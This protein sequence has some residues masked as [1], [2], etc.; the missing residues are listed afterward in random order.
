MQP[1]ETFLAHYG[2]KGMRWGR[3]KDRT[4]QAVEVKASPGRK[5][6]AKGGKFH[7][8]SDDAIIAATRRQQA[9]KSTTDSLS[10]QELQ[11]LV[12]RMNLEQQYKNL[13]SNNVGVGK[14]VARTLLGQV[15]DKQI[16]DLSDYA[17]QT[18]GKEAAGAAARAGVGIAKAAVGGGGK[19]KK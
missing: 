3:R 12:T 7:G 13:N 2:V 15:G 16:N 9:K 14:K 1:V 5:V 19:K 18:T 17:V 6:K 8:P 10:N 4:A 11:Q